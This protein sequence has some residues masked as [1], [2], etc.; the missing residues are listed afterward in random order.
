MK[1]LYIVITFLFLSSI[2]FAQGSYA[3]DF[4]VAVRDSVIEYSVMIDTGRVYEDS[5]YTIPPHDFNSNFPVI[6]FLYDAFVGSSFYF[7]DL[8]DEDIVLSIR[9]IFNK[10]DGY[11]PSYFN[12]RLFF[13]MAV[14]VFK[15]PGRVPVSGDYF[16]KAGEFFG[17]KLPK[18][19]RLIQIFKALNL[20]KDDLGFAYIRDDRFD[21][22]HIETINTPTE[23]RFKAYHFSKF[24]GGRGHI[25]STSGTNDEN[26]IIKLFE[27][28]QNYPNPFNPSTT[29]SYSI[30]KEGYVTLKIYDILGNEV[31]TLVSDRQTAGNYKIEFNGENLSSGIYFYTLRHGRFSSTKKMILMK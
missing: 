12:E 27:L 15:N 2:S 9:L 29:I 20:N 1:R 24:G 28:D 19:D 26:S 3:F 18:S 31:S 6:Q 10:K 17:Y 13:V 7:G 16:F 14:K 21:P 25:S 22:Q 23:V 30:P 4:G 11:A 8:T 5:T